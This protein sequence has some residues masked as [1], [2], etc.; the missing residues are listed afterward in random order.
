MRPQRKKQAEEV[1]FVNDDPWWSVTVTQK[2][3]E[4]KKKK[5]THPHTRMAASI[6][7]ANYIEINENES[8]L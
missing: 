1:C 7:A 8:V 6:M 2:M 3:Q 5:K 4:R